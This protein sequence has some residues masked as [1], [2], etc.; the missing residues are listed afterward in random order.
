MYGEQQ[1]WLTEPVGAERRGECLCKSA[2][3]P[4]LFSLACLDLIALAE[5][6]TVRGYV[7]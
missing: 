1:L 6:L 4:S 5:P 7:L 3:I 2:G